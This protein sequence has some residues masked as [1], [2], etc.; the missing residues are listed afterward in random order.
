MSDV[1]QF[2]LEVQSPFSQYIATGRKTIETRSYPL[3][4]ELLG[5]TIFL[6]ESSQGAALVSN[7]N[8]DV[9]LAGQ[10]GLH[11]IGE[12]VIN[13]CE[14]YKTLEEWHQ[15]RDKHMVPE[16]SLYDMSPTPAGRRW[17]WYIETAV[18]YDRPKSVPAMKRSF[19]SLFE[20]VSD[21]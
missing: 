9:V 7:I 20:C 10:D 13:K 17:G 5:K 15:D 11:F 12:I 1:Q 18:L 14:E 19:R 16:G 3:P 21:A 4:I 6:C 8:G 2:A